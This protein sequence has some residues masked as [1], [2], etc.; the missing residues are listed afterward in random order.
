[1]NG[2]RFQLKPRANETLDGP[3]NGIQFLQQCKGQRVASDDILLAA[4]A[5]RLCPEAT[6]MLDLG[7]GK[8]SVALMYLSANK[9]ATA[10]GMEAYLPS[11]E[12]AVRNR[13]LNGFQSQFLPLFCDIRE[14]NRLID[15]HL[16]EVITGAPPFI[17][18][19]H[20]VLPKNAQR[21][22][23]RVEER[24]GVESYCKAISRHLDPIKGRCVVLMDA[25]N[26][27]RTH[28]AFASAGL[29]LDKQINV[30]PRP[31][32]APIYQ[33]FTGSYTKRPTHSY[34]LAMRENEGGQWS[35]AYKELRNGIGLR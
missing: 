33:I 8:G 26:E 32:S 10:M 22:Y 2:L 16:F 19:G 31:K 25:Q 21:R 35:K 11:F 9:Q 17:Q 18:R 24:G 7:T 34:S 28:A 4:L 12:L 14:S 23:G 13:E 1:M 29:N 5:Y 3:V 6:T 30:L 27:L 15:G 20:G